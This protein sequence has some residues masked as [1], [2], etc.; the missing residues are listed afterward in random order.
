MFIIG[1]L[2]L[3]ERLDMRYPG[4]VRRRVLSE[5]VRICQLFEVAIRG[6]CSEVQVLEPIQCSVLLVCTQFLKLSGGGFSSYVGSGSTYAGGWSACASWV[7]STWYLGAES[8]SRRIAVLHNASRI[9]ARQRA[10]SALRC[11]GTIVHLC[12]TQS[13]VSIEVRRNYSFDAGVNFILN[14]QL[15]QH[16]A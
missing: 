13:L 7:T 15:V 6:F 4:F 10:L 9:C 12:K 16:L 5:N 1:K 11:G 8:S 2:F 3:T 14:N